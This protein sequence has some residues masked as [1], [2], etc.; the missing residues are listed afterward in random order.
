MN[1]WNLNKSLRLAKTHTFTK[2]IKYIPLFFFVVDRMIPL[3][4]IMHRF[5]YKQV[6]FFKWFRNATLMESSSC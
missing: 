5:I 1:V 6:V 2:R 3:M 4:S